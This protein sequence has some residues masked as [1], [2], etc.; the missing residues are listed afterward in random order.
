VQ[1]TARLLTLDPTERAQRSSHESFLS[2]AP[3][4]PFARL[5]VARYL[6]EWEERILKRR[7]TNLFIAHLSLIVCNCVGIAQTADKQRFIEVPFAFEHNQI[8]LQVRVNGKGPYSMLL[9]T[10]TNPSAV[11]LATAREMG[12]KISTAGFPGSG[13]GT[14][15]NL[16]Y[17]TEFPLIEMGGVVARN[18]PALAV[19]LSK[20]SKRLGRPLHGVL[21]YTILKNRIVQID[22]PKLAVRF[23]ASS[24][25]PKSDMQQNNASRMALPFRFV[26]RVPV[27]DV[28]ANGKKIAAVIDTG[29]SQTL[30]LKPNAISK[31]GLQEEVTR[32]EPDTSV[33]YNGQS[34][35]RKG[36]I[37]R[38]S[39]GKITL[40]MPSVT[41]FMKGTGHDDSSSEGGIGNP[42][43]KAFVVTFDYRS[44]TVTIERP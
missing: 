20:P 7:L 12:L 1:V 32:A 19:D 5:L 29:S 31:L 40:E 16:A 18:I 9:D 33:G 17:L 27:I 43:L 14:D 41:F 22:Y 25:F 13:G 44:K 2:R 4:D 3:A 38:L 11:D 35:V 23:Y 15:I 37:N 36:R 6:R 10:G 30:S 42:F 28:Y 24:P 34:E 21:G 39:V 26:D 8:I